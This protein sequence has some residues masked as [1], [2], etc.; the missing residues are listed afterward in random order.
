M[1]EYKKF[2]L[3]NYDP[4]FLLCPP[5]G[6]VEN[7]LMYLSRQLAESLECGTQIPTKKRSL[8]VGT[9][10]ELFL[11]TPEIEPEMANLLW[12]DDNPN[13]SGAH[14]RKIQRINS[15]A[16]HLKESDPLFGVCS[17]DDVGRL[18]VEFRTLPL[19]LD[20]YYTAIRRLA[21]GLRTRCKN[22]GVIP[23]V[24]S[25]H[26]HTSLHLG[27]ENLIVK[28]Y[29]EYGK[30]IPHSFRRSLAKSVS[31]LIPLVSLPEEFPMRLNED[32][33]SYLSGYEDC[34]SEW[35]DLDEAKRSEFRRL[36]SEYA[37]DPALNLCV[38]LRALFDV[39]TYKK[40]SNRKMYYRT[41]TESIRHM[42]GMKEVREFFGESLL[43]SL[44]RIVS[45]YPKVSRGDLRVDQVRL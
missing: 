18:T 2:R 11:F 9:E 17:N 19:D 20:D 39:M 15:W 28:T 7:E 24:F 33:V 40:F 32:R 45:Q 14:M 3:E 21:E 29:N 22:E 10:L 38:S 5:T 41:Q 34:L 16:E 12:E 35:N 25:Q 44:T 13:Y 42:E 26:I 36:S 30:N 6:C 4:E 1:R 27:N 37:C 31:Q 8:K 23:V 43:L